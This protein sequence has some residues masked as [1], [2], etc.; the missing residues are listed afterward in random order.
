MCKILSILILL[1]IS[2]TADF[3][4]AAAVLEK[5]CVS[6]HNPDKTKGKLDLTT[7]E[8]ILTKKK[9]VIPGKP[10]ESLIIEAVSG[11]E[12]EMPP[13]GETL[14]KAE[15]KVLKVWIQNG[16]KWDEG[17]VLED[18]PNVDLDWWSLK[19]IT[20]TAVSGKNPVD[21]LINKSLKAKNLKANKEA[22]PQVLIRRISYDL[23]GLPPT[24][25]EIAA[26]IKS[27][28]VDPE[29]AWKQKVDE[30]LA[31]PAFGEKWGQ[32]WLDVA[33][34]ADSHGYDK[35]KLRRN[36]W[37]YRDYVIRSLNE[38]KPFPRFVQEQV[39]GD[40]IFPGTDDGIIGLGFLAAGP[41][42]FVGHEEVSEDKIDGKI[43][44]HSDR[45]EMV[46]AVFNV[47]QSTTVQCAACHHHKFD[48]VRME[49]YYRLHAVFS[50][51][52]RADRPYGG[53]P[54]E[55]AERQKINSQIAELN[56]Q[57]K[58]IQ[59]KVPADKRRP[60]FGF[61]SKI[62]KKQMTKKWVQIDLGKIAELGKI[63]LFP[64][65]DDYNNI[66]AGFGF[67]VRYMVEASDTAD[68]KNPR[69]IYKSKAD[70]KRPYKPVEITAV[71]VK[72]RFIRMTA[73]KLAPRSNDFI[74]ALDEMQVLA[75]KSEDNIASRAKVTSLD[76][77]E[78]KPRWSRRNLTD[79]VK[80]IDKNGG[81]D[82]AKEIRARLQ[83]ID[84]QLA[85]LNKK[86]NGKTS[87]VYAAATHF[88]TRGKFKATQGKKRSI[89]LLH[90]GDVTSPG[91]KMKAGAPP[92][93]KGARSVFTEADDWQEAEGRKELAFYL[94][95]KENPLLWRSIANRLW[96]WTFGKAIV[97]T[98]NDFGRMGMKPSHP[99]LLD[100][101]AA[102]LR[103]DPKHSLKSI[104]RMLV[105]SKTYRRSS[106][107]SSEN[108]NID[109]G[110][111][112]LWRYNR[113]RLS[114]EEYRDSLLYVS[115]RLNR[116]AGGPGFFDFVL[117]K[118]AHSPHY[119]YHLFNHTREESHR[120]SIYR[121][122]ARSQPQPFL[123]TL[124]CADPSL[125]VARRNESTTALQALAQW[126]NP[127]VE[128]MAG[129]FAE[130]YPK[131]DLR[132]LRKYSELVLGRKP[133][134]AEEKIL[135]KQ[136]QDHGVAN[137]ARVL[138]NMSAFTYVN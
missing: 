4:K 111:K 11:D 125:S 1:Q 32:H 57:K 96:L 98:P 89:H 34:Y 50:A 41:W 113:R 35:D 90:R 10:L 6:C 108:K 114:A 130:K 45:D 36:A 65:Y 30:L 109:A 97:E 42:D 77:I 63:R 106:E 19:S 16:A 51:V 138:F 21:T 60:E 102:Q 121:F 26:F 25:E 82:K 124:D 54:S 104:V 123:T 75:V 81:N 112:Y 122:I 107:G 71:G 137:L 126:N 2:L 62:V 27:Y 73:T 37:P 48:P 133:T 103:D 95:D 84:R 59:K 70:E 31:R 76:S 118:T 7:R 9:A 80:F 83:K 58:D 119:E 13:K 74:F 39:A 135:L 28:N 86:R 69:V 127:F 49:D 136:L 72:G 67:P 17:R 100:F 128:V 79:G 33:R 110:N 116:K 20:K 132:S 134:A 12:P 5:R 115:G 92:L 68:F 61:H 29:K 47:F 88:K 52:D 120:R 94:T 101:L 105:M 40:I 46:S 56:K 129:F 44:R 14:T 131:K 24:P 15:I 3:K 85:E 66:G 18:N 93:W 87:V 23:T 91:K 22:P 64:S 8:K 55:L 43:A 38:D 117:Q 99:E 53:S 78:A